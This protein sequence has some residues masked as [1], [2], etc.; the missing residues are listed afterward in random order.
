MQRS[1]ITTG[2]RRARAGHGFL[3]GLGGAAF[4]SLCCVG[5]LV[6]ILV[7]G[8]TAAGAV[9]LVRFK[10]EFIAVGFAVTLLGIGLSLRKS[11]ASCTV[12]AYRRN[13]VLIPAVSLLVFALVV[14][15]SNLLLL[16]DGII[17]LASTRLTDDTRQDAAQV[18]VPLAYQLDVEITSG[19]YCPACLL[20]IQKKVTDT[21]GVGGLTF[22]Q[23][24]DGNFVARIVYDPTQVDQGTLLT[25]IAGAPGSLG[26]VYGT[27]TL[28][29]G[30]AT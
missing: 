14:V 8:G 27:K 16:N 24:A 25:T 18:A 2:H 10:L 3:W 26:G 30:P 17:S 11:K 5:P 4:A 21:P 9:G 29:D 12:E 22:D 13:R 20:A 23:G 7:A 19:V 28:R 6:A 1:D 15:A